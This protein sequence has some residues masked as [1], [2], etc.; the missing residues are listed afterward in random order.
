M[1]PE[2]GGEAKRRKSEDIPRGFPISGTEAC[3]APINVSHPCCFH[4]IRAS[5][6]GWPSP[7]LGTFVKFSISERPISHHQKAIEHVWS[8]TDRVYMLCRAT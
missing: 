3:M 7:V 5:Q 2:I 4:C 8:P 6:L 1:A